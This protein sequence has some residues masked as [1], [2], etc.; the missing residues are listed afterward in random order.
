MELTTEEIREI[1]E[2]YTEMISN[3]QTQTEV[4]G[5]TVSISP[6]NFVKIETGGCAVH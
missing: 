6:I 5:M 3:K 1:K 2:I 4:N